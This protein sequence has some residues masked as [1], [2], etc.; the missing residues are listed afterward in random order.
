M[1]RAEGGLAPRSPFESVEMLPDGGARVTL[2][3]LSKTCEKCGGDGW[4][5]FLDPIPATRFGETEL[6]E[7]KGCRVLTFCVNHGMECGSC[8]CSR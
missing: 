6:P 5:E 4:V 3:N 8:G 2:A 7:V 1:A